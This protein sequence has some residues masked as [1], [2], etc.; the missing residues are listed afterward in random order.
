M[1]Y[2]VS[3]YTSD[4][5]Q[6]ENKTDQLTDIDN[7]VGDNSYYPFH[8][9]KITPVDYE[10]VSVK[11]SKY[12]NCSKY[13]IWNFDRCMRSNNLCGKIYVEASYVRLD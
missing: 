8:S 3:R 1:H 11:N 13:W 12:P 2:K 4:E 7:V 5:Y 9:P 10:C 6:K